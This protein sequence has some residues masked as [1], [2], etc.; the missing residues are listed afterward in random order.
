[1]QRQHRRHLKGKGGGARG[2]AGSWAWPTLPASPL[3]P[4]PPLARASPRLRRSSAGHPGAARWPTTL[5]DVAFRAPLGCGRGVQPPPTGDRAA[6]SPLPPPPPNRWKGQAPDERRAYAGGR[7][8]CDSAPKRGVSTTGALSTAVEGC[9]TRRRGGG[10][11]GGGHVGTPRGGRGRLQPVAAV[12]GCERRVSGGGVGDARSRGPLP[13]VLSASVGGC[14][15]RRAPLLLGRQIPSRGVW[16][17]RAAG[18]DWGVPEEHAKRPGAVFPDR[19]GGGAARRRL[20]PV[21]GGGARERQGPGRGRRARTDAGRP[22]PVAAPPRTV[23]CRRL[24][25]W[26]PSCAARSPSRG[27]ACQRKR[28]G[29]L[30]GGRGGGRWDTPGGLGATAVTPAG[31]V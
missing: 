30:A 3:P 11:G 1:M 13:P 31:F 4:P 25:R 27:G 20:R 7:R 8:L 29:G 2:C 16:R 10:E 28:L 23:S 18:S 24:D 19:L 5:G 17:A 21:G 26:K 22:C 12:R 14:A 15:A 9:P 6:S